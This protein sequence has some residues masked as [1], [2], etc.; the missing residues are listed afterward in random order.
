MPHFIH[1]TPLYRKPLTT[2]TCVWSAAGMAWHAAD[3]AGGRLW[4]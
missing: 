2:S 4:T 1:D 3:Q